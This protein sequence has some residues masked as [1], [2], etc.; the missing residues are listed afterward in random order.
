MPYH[1]CMKLAEAVARLGRPE[2]GTLGIAEGIETAL[3]VREAT[4]QVCWAATSAALL[5]AAVLPEN[6]RKVVVW[7]D[8]DLKKAGQKAALRLAER[9]IKEGRKVEVHV[10][11]RPAEKKSWDWADVLTHQGPGGFPRLGRFSRIR[12]MIL[13]S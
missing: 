12:N 13:G 2:N 3:A 10:P 9:L 7:A 5:E 11:D 6:I 4:G 1:S 8:N